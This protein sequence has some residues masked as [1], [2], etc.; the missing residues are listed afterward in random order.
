MRK[1][2]P[3]QDEDDNKEGHTFD[4]DGGHAPDD[5]GGCTSNIPMETPMWDSN[6]MDPGPPGDELR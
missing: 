6:L 5:T 2:E 1:S 4:N 3:E